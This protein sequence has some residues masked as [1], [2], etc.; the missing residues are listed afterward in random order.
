ML[1][2]IYGGRSKLHTNVLEPFASHKQ[3]S[4]VFEWKLGIKLKLNIFLI[5]NFT[6]KNKNNTYFSFTV[7][8]HRV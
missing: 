1:C 7:I 4:H 3:F 5:I 6:E 8:I 2:N